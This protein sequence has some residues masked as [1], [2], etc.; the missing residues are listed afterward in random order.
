MDRLSP[1]VSDVDGT[2]SPAR[3]VRPAFS[4]LMRLRARCLIAPRLPRP[5]RVSPVQTAS[6]L[7][8]E[9]LAKLRKET[10]IAF[11][12]GSDLVKIVGASA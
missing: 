10:A 12:G 1:L 8:L 4:F 3:Q 11:V 9:T 2:L 7:M 6:P 5:F